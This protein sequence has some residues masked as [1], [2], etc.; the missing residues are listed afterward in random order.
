MSPGWPKMVMLK[1]SA[2]AGRASPLADGTGGWRQDRLLGAG[3][4]GTS[5][6]SRTAVAWTAQF[7]DRLHLRAGLIIR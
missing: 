3:T 6:Y 4:S 7:E 2:A 1:K 5:S